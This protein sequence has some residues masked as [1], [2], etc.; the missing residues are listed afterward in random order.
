M[1]ED[2]PRTAEA[3]TL[4]ICGLALTVDD[5][6]RAFASKIVSLETLDV[7]NDFPILAIDSLLEVMVSR[8][9]TDENCVHRYTETYSNQSCFLL[10]LFLPSLE[11]T[12][13]G[14]DV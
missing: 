10:L 1:E 4:G 9:G 13:D 12:P 14:C 3:E 2:S 11:A 6:S 5:G 7:S 8:T